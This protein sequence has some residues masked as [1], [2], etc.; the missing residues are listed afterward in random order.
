MNSDALRLL[1]WQL[2]LPADA[3]DSLSR[4]AEKAGLGKCAFL[5][6]KRQLKTEGFLH[7]W[8]VQGE[9]GRWET[10]QL[11]SGAPLSAEEAAAV[12]DGE[13]AGRPRKAAAL[14]SGSPTSGSPT[15]GS[16]AVGTPAVGEPTRRD[17]GRHP[18]RQD[19][20]DNT[21]TPPAPE[22]PDDEAGRFVA[23]LQ[24]RDARLRIPRAMVTE[25]AARVRDWFTRGHTAESVWRHIRLN[26]PGRLGRIE[27]PGGLLRYVL[28]DIPPVAVAVLASEPARRQSAPVPR[29]SLMRE[30]EGAGHVQARLF[31]P[32]GDETLCGAC[33]T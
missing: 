25:L 28:A 3:G 24:E 6:A 21:S 2:S 27:R 15:S 13:P 5:R 7:E 29:V 19:L 11:V 22:R 30:C 23:G 1:I 10:V 26:L 9:R 32:T 20:R 14:T 31:L 18:R 17:V 33:R 8:R 4:T 16:P 12:R